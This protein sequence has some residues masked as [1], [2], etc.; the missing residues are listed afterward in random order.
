MESGQS[1]INGGKLTTKYSLQIFN[2]LIKE[3]N[4]DTTNQD[5]EE[6]I[7]IQKTK[8][9]CRYCKTQLNRYMNVAYKIIAVSNLIKNFIK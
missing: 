5:D 1:F 2:Q 6:S 7:E 9:S 8:E 3:W 4:K